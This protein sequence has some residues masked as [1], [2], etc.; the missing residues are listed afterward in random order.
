M[1]LPRIFLWGLAIFCVTL[2]LS[3][4]PLNDVEY[5]RVNGQSLKLDLHLT[6]NKGQPLLV[7]VHGGAW[8]GGTKETPPI[9]AL[10]KHGF[11]IASVDYRLTTVAPFPANV[12]DIKAAIRFLRAKAPIYGYDATRIGIIGVSA[13]GHLAAL[14]G[15]TN[16]DKALEGEVG[17]DLAQDR[18][19]V[20]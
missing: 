15:V 12:H 16:A 1:T 2:P 9:L 19:S 11:A 20:V 7:F 14:V 18:K 6:T 8:R 13:G 3:A 10:Q 5:A 4:E 17:D